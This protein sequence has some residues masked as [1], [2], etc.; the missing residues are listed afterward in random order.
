M[1]ILWTAYKQKGTSERTFG[2]IALYIKIAYQDGDKLEGVAFLEAKKRYENKITFDAIK[3]NQLKRIYKHAPHSMILLYDYEEIIRK[4]FWWVLLPVRTHTVIVPLNVVLPTE[5]KDMTLYKFSSPFSY[6]LCFR[7]FKGR[8]LEFS[9]EAIQTA[10][11]FMQKRG[12]PKN[13]IT[14]SIAY[15]RAEIDREFEI[16]REMY[17]LIGNNH[18]IDNNM[19]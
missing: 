13:L 17:H 15:G 18:P 19:R 5:K 14:I 16:N 1:K 10:Q 8:D 3:P 7:Y 2:D 6:Q 11:G 4:T 9:K 12:M